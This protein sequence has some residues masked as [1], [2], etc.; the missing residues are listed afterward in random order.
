MRDASIISS[1][2]GS[3]VWILRPW[4]PWLEAMLI[5]FGLFMELASSASEAGLPGEVMLG[6]ERFIH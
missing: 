1:S 2:L 4:K 3:L 6:P 5:C